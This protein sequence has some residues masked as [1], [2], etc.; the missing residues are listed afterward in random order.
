LKEEE[1]RPAELFAEYLHLAEKDAG[2]FFPQSDRHNCL[3]PACN[4]QGQKIFSKHSFVYKECPECRTLFVS[5]RPGVEDLH[6]Y[7]RESPSARFF[8]TTFYRATSEARRLKLWRPK[9]EKVLNLLHR[10]GADKFHLIDIGGGYG[11]FAKEFERL[12][13]RKVLVVEP[14]P[15]SAA[16]CRQQGLQVMESFLEDLLPGQ[17]PP[18]PKAFVSFELF[19]HLHHPGLF[20]DKL[21]SLMNPGDLFLFTTLNGMGLD[22]QVLW[23][24]SNSFSLQHLQFLNPWSIRFLLKKCQFESLVVETPGK[25]DMDILKKNQVA[26]TDRFWKR[27]LGQAEDKTLDQWQEFI[28]SQGFSS[29][30][31]VVCRRGK[32][33]EY[34]P[35][36]GV[37]A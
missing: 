16:A 31:W 11:I 12:S 17:L 20:L 3:C 28:S 19:E 32:G 27:L 6:R 7:Y 36:A 21:G 33:N 22:I 8:G 2:E 10:H 18:G 30:M 35:T 4:N 37:P 14:G 5:P 29:H 34:K 1:I 24:K 25:L 26:I 9:A 13:S 15:D 23:E